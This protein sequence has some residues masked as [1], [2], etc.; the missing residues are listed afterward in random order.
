MDTTKISLHLASSITDYGV[1][2]KIEVSSDRK[3]WI[4]VDGAYSASE[5]LGRMLNSPDNLVQ[6]IYIYAKDIK[7]V[8]MTQIGSSGNSWWSIAELD[9]STLENQL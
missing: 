7:Y 8:K 6:D 3:E 5:F 9:I 4:H 2:F 1:D